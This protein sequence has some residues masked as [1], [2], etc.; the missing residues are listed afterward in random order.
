MPIEADANIT[1]IEEQNA[2]LSSSF[3]RQEMRPAMVITE[4]NQS[5]VCNQYSASS[6]AKELL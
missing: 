4:D 3:A 6:K 1:W 5:H 2:D